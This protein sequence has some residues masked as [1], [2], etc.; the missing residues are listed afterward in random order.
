MVRLATTSR[1]DVV[2]A[3][4]VQADSL[5]Y[6]SEKQLKELSDKVPADVKAKVE[7]K[8]EATREALKGEDLAAVKV[9]PAPGNTAA[10]AAVCKPAC[11]LRRVLA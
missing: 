8:M 3:A 7:E 10:A 2:A 11:L 9:A 1:P 5:V 4:V 6:Q